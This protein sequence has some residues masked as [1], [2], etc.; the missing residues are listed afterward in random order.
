MSKVKIEEFDFATLWYHPEKRIVH[1]EFHKLN[2][3]DS[4]R[5][6]LLKGTELMKEKG[7][8]K[9]LS[10]DRKNPVLRSEDME[11]G[12]Q[13]WFPKTLEAGWKYWAIVTPEKAITKANMDQLAEDYTKAGVTTRF[14]STPEE[15]L[16]WLE[17]LP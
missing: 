12:A 5:S 16:A 7:A 3:G 14:F 2:Y 1:H 17:S 9:W 6:F 8:D 15:A 11:W 10:D 4:L 13:N